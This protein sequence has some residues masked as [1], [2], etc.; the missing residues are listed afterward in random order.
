MPGMTHR[1]LTRRLIESYKFGHKKNKEPGASL[2]DAWENSLPPVINALV[3]GGLGKVEV[4]VEFGLPHINADVDVLLA[5]VHPG[6]YEPSYVLIELK[7]QRKAATNPERSVAV[8]LG[9]DEWKLHPVRQVQ[10]YCEYLMEYKAVLRG[11]PKHVVGA[12]LMHNAHDTDVQGLFDL[13][14][15]NHGRLYTLDRLEA[16]RKML[17]ARLAAAPGGEVAEALLNSKEYELPKIVNVATSLRLNASE[18]FPLLD[19]QEMARQEVHDAIRRVQQGGTK[20]VIIVRGGPGSG[21]SAIALELLRTL[22]LARWDAV[23]ASGAQALTTTLRTEYER[24]PKPG[25]K[26]KRERAARRLFTYFMELKKLDPNSRDVVICDEAHRI[27]RNSTAQYTRREDRL[28]PL[29][30]ADEIIA[31]AQVPVFL[32]DDYQSLRPDEVG[33]AAYLADRADALGL[34]YTV[35]DLGKMMF[36]AQGSEYFREWVLDLLSLGVRTPKPW[37]PDGRM[38]IRMADSPEEMEEFL[39]ARRLEGMRTRIVAGFCWPWSKPEDGALVPDVIIGD[40]ERPWNVKPDIH[41]PDAPSANLW[42]TDP[43]GVGQIGCVYTAQ[44]FEF[45]WVGVIIGPDLVWDGHRLAVQRDET[46][47]PKLRPKTVDDLDVERCVRNAYHVLLTR[48]IMGMT[49]FATDKAT[50]DALRG[51]VVST[52]NHPLPKPMRKITQS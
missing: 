24:D 9:Y 10:K 51:F 29:P 49:V 45:D 27:R 12:V 16:F 26:G 14:E 41:V 5:G 20:E 2:I 18:H 32:L 38:Q 43:R 47:D 23:H 36:R 50:Q 4:F 30:Q 35:I 22:K 37:V 3:E 44:T 21:K 6:S 39:E 33:T 46:S 28:N 31:S 13:P 25:E 1:P 15:S 48:G 52:M 8:D 40:W 34:R 19:E 7:Q 11:N 42:A 17:R